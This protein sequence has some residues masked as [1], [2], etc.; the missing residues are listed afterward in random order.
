[1]PR[2]RPGEKVEAVAAQ[3]VI[4]EVSWPRDFQDCV[5]ERTVGMCL[6][7]VFVFKWQRVNLECGCCALRPPRLCPRSPSQRPGSQ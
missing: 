4:K 5:T 7:V 2:L 1:M 6:V 3:E